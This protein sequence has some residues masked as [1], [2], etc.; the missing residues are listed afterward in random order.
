MDRQFAFQVKQ[1][2][3]FFERFNFDNSKTIFLKKY[4]DNTNS[5]NKDTLKR[6][7]FIKSL[8]LHETVDTVVVK[9]FISFIGNSIYPISY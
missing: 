4:L 2:D 7:F 6:D 8:F 9:E 5:A 1:I 3:E